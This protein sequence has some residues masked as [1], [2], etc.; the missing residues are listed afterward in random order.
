MAL[1][2]PTHPPTHPPTKVATR[3]AFDLRDG[4]HASR[5]QLKSFE[6]FNGSTESITY[7]MS[8]SVD[9]MWDAGLLKVNTVQVSWLVAVQLSEYMF[10][11][12]RYLLSGGM[13][14][15]ISDLFTIDGK[16][17]LRLKHFPHALRRDPQTHQLWARDEDLCLHKSMSIRPFLNAGALVALHA[18]SGHDSCTEF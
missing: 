14:S 15:V 8:S 1:K 5:F 13:L 18:K 12:G 17:Y 6:R 16:V 7:G 10:R 4:A 9:A 3:R 2:D 11:I